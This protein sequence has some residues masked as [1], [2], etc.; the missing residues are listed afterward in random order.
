MNLTLSQEK[1]LKEQDVTTQTFRRLD[2][3]INLH[4]IMTNLKAGQGIRLS[5]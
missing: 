3:F 2:I 4:L 5:Q 1:E